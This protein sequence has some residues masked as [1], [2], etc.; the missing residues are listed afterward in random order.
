MHASAALLVCGSRCLI[1]AAEWVGSGADQH[2]P[3]VAEL[4]GEAVKVIY[5]VPGPHHHLEGWNQLTAGSA[6]SCGA[7][8]PAE[9][10]VQRAQGPVGGCGEQ[11]SCLDSGDHLPPTP[12]VQQ[13]GPGQ[14]EGAQ[15]T[16]SASAK[17]AGF[18]EI[19]TATEE[20][21]CGD[22]GVG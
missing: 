7:E 5:V 1:G 12:I 9:G 11:G 10:R 13:V 8:E 20:G 17:R 18:R 3:L 2:S 16:V 15:M 21:D 22:S 6:V 14:R 19:F 4:V